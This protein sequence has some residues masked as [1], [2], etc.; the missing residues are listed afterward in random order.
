LSDLSELVRKAAGH[1]PRGWGIYEDSPLLVKAADVLDECEHALRLARDYGDTAD[2]TQ[3]AVRAALAK[4][5]GR[6]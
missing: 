3:R 1:F 4:L 6:A 5:E 2:E